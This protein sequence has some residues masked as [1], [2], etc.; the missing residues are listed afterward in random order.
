MN[1]TVLR[2]PTAKE[3]IFLIVTEYDAMALNKGFLFWGKKHISSASSNFSCLV[4]DI[5]SPDSC[6][7]SSLEKLQELKNHPVD[8]NDIVTKFQLDLETIQRIRMSNNFKFF[9]KD[10]LLLLQ[11]FN[12]EEYEFFNLKDCAQ[13]ISLELHRRSFW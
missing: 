10:N 4:V 12:K 1:F 3:G 7:V 6:P 5:V 13:Y 8:L 2:R 11:G 9:L